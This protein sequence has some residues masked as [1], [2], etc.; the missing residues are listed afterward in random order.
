M[1]FQKIRLM[2]L[3]FFLVLKILNLLPNVQSLRISALLLDLS[4]IFNRITSLTIDLNS[5]IF[6]KSTDILHQMSTYLPNIRYLYFELKTSQD[7]Y[8]FLIYCLRKLVNLLDIHVT[9]HEP[10]TR[11]DRQGLILWFNEFKLLNGLNNRI[12]V[13]FGDD[14]NRLHISL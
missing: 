1:I 12:Q 5:N 9:I 13:E 7:I 14:D 10:N 4:T 8:I 11:I 6:Y 3:V 2:I